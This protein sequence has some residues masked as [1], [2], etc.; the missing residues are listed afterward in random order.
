MKKFCDL[1]VLAAFIFSI[2]SGTFA[3]QPGATGLAALA[4]ARPGEVI[5]L[6]GFFPGKIPELPYRKTVLPG[7]RFIISDDPEYI[8]DAESIALQE[9][10]SPGAVR[11]YV[12]N[13]NGVTAPAKMP[14]KI[15]TLIKNTGKKVMHLHFE[16]FSSQLPSAN[17]YQIGKQG[18]ADYFQ[19]KGLDSSFSIPPGEA[20]PIDPARERQV[21]QYDE[22]VHGIYE[23]TID[24][25]AEITVLQTSPETPGP[26]A[27]KRMHSV[28]PPSHSNAGRGLFSICNYGISTEKSIDTRDGPVTLT[29]ADGKKDPWITGREGSTGQTTTLSGN[30]GV[31]YNI[32]IKWKSTDGRGLALVTWNPWNS[33]NQWCGGMA[34][35][36]VVSDGKYKGGVIQLPADRLITT[37]APEA[38]LIQTF[39]P[40]VTGQEQ[41]IRLTYSPPGASCLPT[42]LVLIPVELNK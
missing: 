5:S 12:Y 34:N 40:S 41:I 25:P 23:F 18:L 38:I 4:N 33:N 8:R 10:V 14:R 7:P 19:S 32:K 24:Q 39:Q 9:K 35:T 3:Q 27:M 20:I 6:P 29:I 2:Q 16:K 15:T 21:V 11:L 17:Y 42:P 31:I 1:L 36:V 30:Y 37:G 13:V 26:V 28:V 22:L